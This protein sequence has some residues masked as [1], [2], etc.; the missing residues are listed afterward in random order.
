M[1]ILFYI[2]ASVVYIMTIHFA[3]AI[4]G[5]FNLFLMAGIFVF[6]GV[7][8][9]YLGSLGAGFVGAVVLSL[10]FW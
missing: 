2:V 7:V 5:Q 3:I 10:I 4:K 9:L 8:G 6:G 1:D